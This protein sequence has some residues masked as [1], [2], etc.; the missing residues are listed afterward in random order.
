MTLDLLAHLKTLSAA[1]GLSGYEGPARDVIR[2]AW[3]PLTDELHQ[4]R[5]GTL[6][7]VRNGRGAE[8]RHRLML[9]AHRDAIGLLVTRIEG[10]ILPVAN[11]GG[12]DPR[13]RPG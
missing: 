12:T 8:P 9:A 11:I 10:E 5:L 1:A 3:E 7:G 2:P 4:D 13:A 6:W